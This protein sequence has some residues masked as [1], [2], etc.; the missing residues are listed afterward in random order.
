MLIISFSVLLR[1]LHLP[2]GGKRNGIAGNSASIHAVAVS[3]SAD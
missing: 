3:P 2:Q 1:T